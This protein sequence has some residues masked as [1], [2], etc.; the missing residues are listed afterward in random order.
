M[1][2]STLVT[3]EIDAGADLVN[4]FDPYLPVKVAFWL[5][6]TDES[7]WSLYIASDRIDDTNLDLG[8][9]EVLRLAGEMHTPYLDPF[10]VKL[11][12][13]DDPL[14]RAVLDV[15]QRYPGRI[16]IRYNGPSLGGLSIDG[17]YLYPLPIAV[18]AK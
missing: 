17:A 16:P 9:A 14:A 12:P 18:P 7:H 8:Y 15:H 1:D 2:Q 4:R 5:R 6:P 10:Q 13:A 3:E 11:I